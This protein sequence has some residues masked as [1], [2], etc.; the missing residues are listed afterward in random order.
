M[1]DLVSEYQQ[2][3][4]ATAEEE[5]EEFEEDIQEAEMA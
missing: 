2:Y 4:D 3:Q 5:G 1:N